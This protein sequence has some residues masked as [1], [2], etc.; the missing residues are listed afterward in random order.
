MIKQAVRWCGVII[1]AGSVLFALLSYCGFWDRLRGD[2]LLGRYATRLEHSYFDVPSP[3]RPADP[4]WKPLLRVVK[5][6][7]SA[8][9]P[10]DKDPKVF[11]RLP[12]VAS[13]TS[14]FAEWT[15]P[16]TPVVLIYRDWPTN[17]PDV[18]KPKHDYWLVGTIGDLHEW[19]RKDQ[20]DFDFF[21]R[22]LIFGAMSVSVAAFLALP[23][24]TQI[25]RNKDT[26]DGETASLGG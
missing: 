3:V 22:T 9:L 21:W 7:T 25:S 6:Y 26:S 10:R 11:A 24:R 14:M 15:A 16:T 13:A 8:T 1:S 17:T 19:I 5:R 12:A 20:A 18:L 23:D 2:G 4:E